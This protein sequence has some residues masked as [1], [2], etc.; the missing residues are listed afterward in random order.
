VETLTD[1]A[2]AVHAENRVQFFNVQGKA[3]A[4]QKVEGF[5]ITIASEARSSDGRVVWR[6]T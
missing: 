4:S 1:E 5:S 2:G 3:E 6:R